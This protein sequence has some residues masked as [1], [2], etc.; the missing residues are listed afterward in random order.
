MQEALKALKDQ[1]EVVEINTKAFFELRTEIEKLEQQIK[2]LT[3][4]VVPQT[5]AT[6]VQTK[7]VHDLNLEMTEHGRVLRQIPAAGNAYQEYLKSI[8]ESF[9]AM[10]NE[11]NAMNYLGEQFGQI[12]RSAFDAALEGS[13]NFFDMV[14]EGFKNYVKQIL[15]MTAA[16]TALAVAIAF[17]TGGANFK[18]AFNAVGGSM[19]TPLG[20]GEGGEFGLRGRDFFF[21]F[22]RNQTDITRNG[23]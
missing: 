7:A 21:A 14:K 8:T 20:F 11:L 2:D 10:E 12:F 17:V 9:K 16:T 15:A 3:D 18:A 4:G 13:G 23:G 1:F 5:E 19:G 22:K 6:K